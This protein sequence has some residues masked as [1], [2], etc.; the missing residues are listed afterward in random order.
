MILVV[1]L[2]KLLIIYKLFVI[3]I[4][5]IHKNYLFKYRKVGNY[6]DKVTDH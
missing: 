1:F 4:K 5:V 3:I 2:K 6:Y